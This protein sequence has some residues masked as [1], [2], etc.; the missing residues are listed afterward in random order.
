MCLFL[1]GAGRM[2]RRYAATLLTSST[3]FEVEKEVIL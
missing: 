1:V 3:A 2:P